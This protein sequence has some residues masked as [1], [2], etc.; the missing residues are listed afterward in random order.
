M[1]ND[2]IPRPDARFHAWQ[3]NLVTYVNGHLADLGL[4]AGAMATEIRGRVACA[5]RP[6]SCAPPP[7]GAN[8][9][10]FLSVETRTPYCGRLPRRTR[11]QDGAIQ[12]ALGHD[13]RRER[14][15]NRNAECDDGR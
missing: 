2:Y 9:L 8:E 7:T 5:P 12:A 11:R 13:D 1:A 6:R 4:A 10:S 15:A 3:N 14:T